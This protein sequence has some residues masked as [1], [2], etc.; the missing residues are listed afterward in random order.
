MLAARL[1]LNLA[2]GRRELLGRLPPNSGQQKGQRER[3]GLGA[4]DYAASEIASLPSGVFSVMS[5][6]PI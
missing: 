5:P 2:K 3:Y 4:A 6:S 1:A